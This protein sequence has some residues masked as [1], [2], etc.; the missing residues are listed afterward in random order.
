MT[1]VVNKERKGTKLLDLRM[2][3]ML[4]KLFNYKKNNEE[5][6]IKENIS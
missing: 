5:K 4:I 6:Y 2:R 3:A 1:C